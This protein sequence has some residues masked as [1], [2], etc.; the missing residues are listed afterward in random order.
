[1]T[2]QVAYVHDDSLRQAA[3]ARG[4]NYWFAYVAELLDEV[5]VRGEA[6]PFSALEQE[7]AL[8]GVSVLVLGDY[9]ADELP[10]E[11]GEA[12]HE[13][14]EEGGTLIGLATRG[15]DGLFGVASAGDDVAAEPFTV[16]GWMSLD[17][18]DEVSGILDERLPVTRVPVM[19]SFRRL[20]A[21]EADVLTGMSES[22]E[23]AADHPAV[24][25][26]RVG[27]GVA[28][29]FA[30]NLPQS[31][32]THHQ[33]RPITEDVDGDGYLRT[34]D[35]MIMRFGA[36]TTVPCADLMLLVLENILAAAGVPFIHQL[37]PLD[38]GVPDALVHIGGDD[39]SA[40]DRQTPM[41]R[42]TAEMGLPYHVNV[43]LGADGEF[44]FTDEDRRVYEE[45][46][47][48]FSLHFNFMGYPEGVQHP[49]PVE[50]A[51]YDRQLKLFVERYGRLPVCVNTHCLR[52]SGWADTARF[53]AQRG[54]LGENSLIHHRVPPSNPVNLFGTPFG[55]VYPFFVYDD[56]AHGNEKLNFVSL[57]VGFYEP[58][59]YSYEET[60]PLY[61]KVTFN[62]AE[63][64]RVAELA[65]KYEWTLNLF[66]H[67]MNPG[68]EEQNGRW[69]SVRLMMDRAAQLGARVIYV[70]ND[71]L[72]LWWHAR[73]RTR[74]EAGAGEHELTV[75]TE[76][77]EGVLVRFL[78]DA[79]P[80]DVSFVLDG[81]PAHAHSRTR[82]DRAWVYVYVPEGEHTLAMATRD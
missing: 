11:A 74:L 23:G 38:G 26:H 47:H 19:S 40:P 24:T 45:N 22:E 34:S 44:H 21:S 52:A 28:Y 18:S 63:Y 33:G 56:A 41:S 8:A 82:R 35:A 50:E 4:E 72:T 29:Y 78:E 46:G 67:P 3:N 30:F 80:G 1:V 81:R 37:P 10:A 17:G 16:G 49:A 64:I 42:I 2:R 36:A 53:G 60:H 57:P 65:C 66:L 12:L 73:S 77:P 25:R 39:E 55:A 58:G 6:L 7:G 79:L 70:G 62:E 9:S 51:E 54:V 75:R 68:W 13:W 48:E 76:H 15:L 71:A 31:V 61:D 27:A 59:S 32:W 69:D 43:M 14:L 5:G 20:T